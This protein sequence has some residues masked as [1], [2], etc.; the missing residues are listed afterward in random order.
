M[1]VKCNFFLPSI[2]LINLYFY[3]RCKSLFFKDFV[4]TSALSPCPSYLLALP[5]F[6]SISL[7]LLLAL[8]SYILIF[9]FARSGNFF[10]KIIVEARAILATKR[11]LGLIFLF[12][13]APFFTGWTR[14]RGGNR[15][16]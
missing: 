3:M 11:K 13:F 9:F 7:L 16:V 2:C 15:T 1:E 10:I 12:I 6:P 4:L 5:D 14:K 8:T